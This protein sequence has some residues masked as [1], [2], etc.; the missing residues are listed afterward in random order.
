MTRK[1]WSDKIPAPWGEAS[2]PVDAPKRKRRPRTAVEVQTAA[3][4]KRPRVEPA[5]RDG[6][7]QRG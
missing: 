2:G 3:Q 7:A 6:E 4:P 5:G 1:V